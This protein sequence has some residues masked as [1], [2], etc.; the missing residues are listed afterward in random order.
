MIQVMNCLAEQTKQVRRLLPHMKLPHSIVKCTAPG[1]VEIIGVVTLS[2]STVNVIWI[3]PTQ[4]NGIITQY[5]VIYSE[6]DDTD[7]RVTATVASDETSH[8]ILNLGEC[9]DVTVHR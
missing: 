9:S 2:S 3:A 6:Y 5:D 4:R 1:N 8:I 7:S